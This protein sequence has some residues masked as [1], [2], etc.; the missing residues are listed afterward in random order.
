MPGSTSFERL[1]DAAYAF[2]TVVDA[3][4]VRQTGHTIEDFT[5]ELYD[6]SGSDITNTVIITVDE[7]DADSSPTGAYRFRIGI[8]LSGDEGSYTL[9]ITDPLARVYTITFMA[10]AVLFDVA[11]DSTAQIELRIRNTDGSLPASVAIEDLTVRIYNP[12][13]EEVSDELSP[14][15]TELEDGHFILGEN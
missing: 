11:G 2:V 10:Y 13:M 7:L 12:D 9:L 4:H 8:P 5:V 6:P 1:G 15:L 14:M 3:D